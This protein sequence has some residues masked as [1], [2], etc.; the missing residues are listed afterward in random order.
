MVNGPLC[1]LSMLRASTGWCTA[2]QTRDSPRSPQSM[3]IDIL[4]SYSNSNGQEEC[5]LFIENAIRLNQNVC[6]MSTFS[7]ILRVSKKGMKKLQIKMRMLQIRAVIVFCKFRLRKNYLPSVI[8]ASFRN[9]LVIPEKLVAI[10]QSP[11]HIGRDT[12]INWLISLFE[13]KNGY[14][15]GFEFMASMSSVRH[16]W[17]SQNWY[18]RWT[19]ATGTE[20]CKR[21]EQQHF[22]LCW[23]SGE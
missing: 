16:L 2:M 20:Q 17:P 21:I 23:S 10:S 19:I 5:V 12:S 11:L 3:S 13:K 6:Q 8:N 18:F 22:S 1:R 9:E 14:S 4:K 7:L 15:P